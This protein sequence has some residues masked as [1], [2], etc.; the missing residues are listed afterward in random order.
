MADLFRKPARRVPTILQMEN[1]ECGAACLAM[2]LAAY[3]RWETLDAVRDSCGVSRDGASASDILLAA[4]RRGME[5][6]GFRR[7]MAQLR[8]E[9]LPQILFWGFDHFVVLE[10]I[11]RDGF[12][13]VD[14]AHGRRTVSEREF[15]EHYTGITLVLRPGPDFRREGRPPKVFAR[16]LPEVAGSAGMFAT[17][18]LTGVVMLLLAL[19]LPGLTRVFVDD[20]LVEGNGDWLLPLLAGILAIGALRSLL[21]AAYLRG[22]LLLQTKIAAVVSARF[23]W[24]LFHLPFDFFARRSAVEV[25]SR[26]QYA[27][28]LGGVIAG[29]FAQIAVNGIAM[30]G[31]VAVMLSYSAI[32]TGVS[33]ALAAFDLLVVRMVTRR[34]Q[35]QSIHLQTVVGQA[36]ATA[37]QG[38]ALLEQAKVSGGETLLF[39]RMLEA[40]A[41]LINSEQRIGRTIRLLQALPYATSRLS[42]LAL[43]GVGAL[44]VM[45][46]EM[47]LGTL[48]AFLMLGAMM[49]GAVAALITAGT[50]IGQSAAAVGR[51][52][53]ALDHTG[54]IGE[55]PAAAGLATGRV[56]ARQISFA[57]PYGEAVIRD[58]SLDLAPGESIGI[59]GRSG[60]GKSTLA[61]LLVNIVAPTSGTIRFEVEGPDG[62]PKWAEV[63]DGISFVEQLPF[64]PN[65]ALRAAL[66]VWAPAVDEA[67]LLR[68]VADADMGPALAARPGGIDGMIGEGG[69][70][71]SGGERQRLAIA[72]ALVRMPRLLVLDDATSALDE[73][74]ERRILENLKRRGI[75]LVLFTNRASAIRHLDRAAVLHEGVLHGVPIEAAYHAA[76]AQSGTRAEV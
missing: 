5:A 26:T 31:F 47:T 74:A 25:S 62:G 58:L 2:V 3:G 57:Y 14:P 10:A 75:T 42:I 34:V 73:E 23:V 6:D 13:I 35:E 56:E 17:V 66:T 39:G 76:Q 29:P 54:A 60:C 1:A 40:E 28:Q 19:V 20:Y 49:S 18:V 27:G 71:F 21:T 63:P 55:A 9:P 44:L 8:D 46:T 30:L 32:L 53:E 37:V 72:R 33:L 16:I 7:D 38:A 67:Q 24:R 11:A 61:R 36:H 50:A 64:F 41:R 68:A 15:S 69:G 52:G 12:V 70:G 48:L 65:G 51:L 59:M 45:S 4:R 43:L 22:L